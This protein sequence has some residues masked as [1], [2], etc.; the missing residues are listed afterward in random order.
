MLSDEKCIN[1]GT[2]NE[3]LHD[4]LIVLFREE[5]TQK[6]HPASLPPTLYEALQG[7]A[8]KEAKQQLQ[9]FSSLSRYLLRMTSRCTPF[10]LF[11]FV[12]F[13]IGAT[14][15]RGSFCTISSVSALD[16]YGVAVEGYR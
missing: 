13:A 14:G 4:H 11:S 7:F 1:A 6:G 5:Y 2:K 8:S 15:P 3:S 16:G 9:I 10:G 12:G